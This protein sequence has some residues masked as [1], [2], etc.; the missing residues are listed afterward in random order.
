MSKPRSVLLAAII[1]CVAAFLNAQNLLQ[2]TEF[3]PN[4]CGEYG[5]WLAPITELGVER[6]PKGGLDGHDALRLD[7]SRAASFIHNGLKLVSGAKYRL[8]GYVRTK[9]FHAKESGFFLRDADQIYWE[10]STEI[11]PE[12]TNGE[13]V[14][15]EATVTVDKERTDNALFL[16][17]APQATGLLEISEPFLEPDDEAAR[18]GSGVNPPLV[19]TWNRIMPISPVLSEIPTDKATL[20]LAVYT[21]LA[22]PVTDYECLVELAGQS[23]HFPLN[24]EQ[25]VTASLEGLEPGNHTLKLQLVQKTDGTVLLENTYPCTVGRALHFDVPETWLNNLVSELSRQPLVDGDLAFTAPRDGWYWFGLDRADEGTECFLDGGQAPIIRHRQSER[26]E[27]MRQLEAG[28]HRLTVKGAKDGNV[29]TIRTVKQLIIFPMNVAEGDNLFTQ[30]RKAGFDIYDIQFFRKHLWPAFNTHQLQEQYYTAEA[31]PP[32]LGQEARDRGI[33]I[34]SCGG[35]RW[36]DPAEIDKN[37][38]TKNYIQFTDGRALDEICT[39]NPIEKQASVAEGLWRV[40]DFEKPVHLWMAQ[41][42]AYLTYPIIHRPLVAA[43]VNAGQGKG[44]LLIETYI[45]NSPDQESTEKYMTC[46]NEHVR[47]AEAVLPGTTS[48]LAFIFSGFLFAGTYD[49]Y[50]YPQ[51]DIKWTLDYFLWKLANDP[52]L[53]GIFGV[54]FY[55]TNTCDEEQLRWVGALMRHYCID[56]KREM[57][58][59]SQGFSCNPGHLRNCD[60]DDGLEHWTPN[61][62]QPDSIAHWYRKDY[63]RKLQK[64]VND[65]GLA[66]GDHAALFSRS[67]KGPNKLTQKATGLTP[68]RKYALRFTTADLDEIELPQGICVH[69][70]FHAEISNA[71]ILPELGYDKHPQRMEEL[72]WVPKEKRRPRHDIVNH[73]VV[74]IPHDTE[75][76]ITF[77][78]WQSEDEAGAPIGQCRILNFINLTPYF[79]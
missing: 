41:R 22:K 34:F 10:R 55:S 72:W 36:N 42:S 57:L 40:I 44:G 61:P 15:M 9:G 28:E 19:H 27:T 21:K 56:G 24:R 17:R 8:G 73:K 67:L 12:D 39:W 78:D 59:A 26:S 60:F 70:A 31:V 16:V 74:F 69:Y 50:N 53:K 37:I 48:R 1:F 76:E 33:K 79:E 14:K 49:L 4:E 38:R 11:F 23:Q 58:S 13:W 2:D 75:V 18:A 5:R 29:L 62:A 35:A 51:S 52:E 65:E 45:S 71:Q 25:Q 64:R 3:Q 32:S 43:A 46:L 6:L 68:G 54:G 20:E 47:H 7:F 63:G 66:I 30:L 77:S